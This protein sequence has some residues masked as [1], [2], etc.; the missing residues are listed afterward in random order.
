M[1]TARTKSDGSLEFVVP[2][3]EAVTFTGTHRVSPTDPTIVDV[4]AWH[5]DITIR[6]DAGTVLLTKTVTFGANGTYAWSLTG[7]VAG[8]STTFVGTRKA[9]IWRTDSGQEEEVGR[10]TVMIT[11]NAKYGN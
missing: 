8:E 6:D 11:P 4:S 9:E 5:G 1:A 10:G 3:G 7:G 2:K